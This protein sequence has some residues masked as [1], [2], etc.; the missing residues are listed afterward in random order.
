[1]SADVRTSAQP[2]AIADALSELS[3]QLLHSLQQPETD[4]A[5]R[6]DRNRTALSGIC[7]AQREAE[8]SSNDQKVQTRVET[9]HFRKGDVYWTSCLKI[10]RL[11]PGI[12][13]AA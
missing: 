12:W 3:K 7:A 2:V 8:R 6:I 11:Q 10:H 5:Q 4:I 9:M 13:R 1:M